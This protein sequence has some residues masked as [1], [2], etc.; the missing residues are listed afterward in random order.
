MKSEC[1]SPPEACHA[2]STAVVAHSVKFDR[3]SFWMVG[4]SREYVGRLLTNCASFLRCDT[5][6]VYSCYV[7]SKTPSFLSIRYFEFD[8]RRMLITRCIINHQD[9]QHHHEHEHQLADAAARESGPSASPD[10]DPV[11]H[12][13]SEQGRLSARH[14]A[15]AITD[16][17]AD[18]SPSSSF[19]DPSAEVAAAP[20]P[21][22]IGRTLSRPE[23]APADS[24][25]S[26]ES[27]RI[28][29]SLEEILEEARSIRTCTSNGPRQVG[30]STTATAGACAAS[31]ERGTMAKATAA[32]R[33][34]MAAPGGGNRSNAV[35]GRAKSVASPSIRSG[36][37]G[38]GRGVGRA[39]PG[40][41]NS[42]PNPNTTTRAAAA[43]RLRSKA[44][45]AGATLESSASR[46]SKT[47]T[48]TSTFGAGQITPVFGHRHRSGV[49]NTRSAGT[50]RQST[51]AA[52]SHS[53]GSSG[54][55]GPGGSKGIGSR[56]AAR[57]KPSLSSSPSSAPQPGRPE[58]PGK[59][60]QEQKQGQEVSGP[61]AAATGSISKVVSANLTSGMWEEVARYEAARRRF[62]GRNGS[63]NSGDTS[64]GAG[65][66]SGA[67]TSSRQVLEAAEEALM[68]GLDSD[69]GASCISG[70]LQG[71]SQGQNG[72]QPD[73][74][75][76][77]WRKL[78]SSQSQLPSQ[79]EPH[80]RLFDRHG[81][82]SGDGDG[83]DR[84]CQE[85]GKGDMAEGE[86]SRGLEEVG[87]ERLEEVQRLQRSL[88][89][90]LDEVEGRRE[91]LAHEE[92]QRKR[93]VAAHGGSDG[94]RA[95]RE[96]GGGTDRALPLREF[97][98]W[99]C[100]NKVEVGCC[101]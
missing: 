54:A 41:H 21:A 90:L 5:G 98:D 67:A 65:S 68:R 80:S 100:W 66:S 49:G 57:R 17:T 1:G 73:P 94:R 25:G 15:S 60:D 71:G 76:V 23:Q 36:G 97:E 47:G 13:E 31:R 82:G 83:V 38:R 86:D 8:V 101:C 22:T 84:R 61:G 28:T 32:E 26:E 3:F 55:F 46:C 64:G 51:A 99:Y 58:G 16:T 19:R 34:A 95:E 52:S 69:S 56:V 45:A 35:G 20:Q 2:Q 42:N 89:M 48:R 72:K 74:Q 11:W 53:G 77:E 63:S 14:V 96:D 81:T 10:P 62:V 59:Q 75:F 39:P 92:Q 7:I 79:R 29:K 40:G 37:R 78:L 9:N 70:C 4:V 27:L 43:P 33:A 87:P 12:R 30:I 6:P 50:A 88:L 18:T 93:N 91:L 85:D 24:H 44:K